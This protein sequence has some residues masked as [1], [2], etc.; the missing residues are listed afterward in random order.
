MGY[1]YTDAIHRVRN[2]Q[3]HNARLASWLR[4]VS[5]P[6]E[7]QHMRNRGRRS[8]ATTPPVT[9]CRMVCTPKGRNNQNGGL[10]LRRGVS[11]GCAPSGCEPTT[12]VPPGESSLRSSAPGYP[13]FTP[14]GV[15][16][17]ALFHCRFT[18]NYYVFGGR[19]GRASLHCTGGAI[20]SLSSPPSR[21]PILN[22]EFRILNCYTSFRGSVIFPVT[23]AAAATSGLARMVLAPGP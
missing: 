19:S 20:A 9:R 17:P 15:M 5:L 11:C 10:C 6:R 18:F 4:W 12:A 14:V 2:A 16:I 23:A 7:G 22:F 21:S 13:C 8:A 1:V 3:P